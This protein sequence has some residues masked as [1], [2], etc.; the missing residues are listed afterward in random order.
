MNRSVTLLDAIGEVADR[1]LADIEKPP[2]RRTVLRIV[3]AAA[4]LA[5]IVT[6]VYAAVSPKPCY[7]AALPSDL[8]YLYVTVQMPAPE[9]ISLE[10]LVAR[11]DIIISGKVTAEHRKPLEKPQFISNVIN[12]DGYVA[13]SFDADNYRLTVDV[14]VTEVLKGDVAA[15]DTLTVFNRAVEVYESDGKYRETRCHFDTALMEKG[16]RVLLFL[17]NDFITYDN[18][19]WLIG[20]AGNWFRGCGGQ[21]HCGL[22][23]DKRFPEEYEPRIGLENY[24]SYTLD[25]WK[26]IVDGAQ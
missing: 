18:E 10:E 24:E 12:A 22:L 25:E 9:N 15:G 16:D 19:Y 4:C 17:T 8:P 21:Y 20:E 3:A 11:S 14:K 6:A 5:L 7:V 2:H 23:D 13:Y 1:H 26:A